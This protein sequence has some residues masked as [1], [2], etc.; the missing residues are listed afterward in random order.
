MEC[1]VGVRDVF[2][3]RCNIVQTRG[4]RAGEEKGSREEPAQVPKRS[5]PWCRRPALSAKHT[6]TLLVGVLTC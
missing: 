6:P 5:R 3:D 4:R 2:D 1:S